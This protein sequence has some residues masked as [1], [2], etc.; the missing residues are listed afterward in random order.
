MRW[1]S[2][3]NI[4]LQQRKDMAS[5]LSRQINNWN[6]QLKGYDK[7]EPAGIVELI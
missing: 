2:F 5:M 6:K 3:K 7:A 4:T 1:Q